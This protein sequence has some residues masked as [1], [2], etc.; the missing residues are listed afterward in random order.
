MVAGSTAGCGKG[1]G[2]GCATQRLRRTFTKDLSVLDR[3]ASQL[4]E[5]KTCCNLSHSGQSAIRGKESP[6]R[7]GQS[8]HPKMPTRRKTTDHVKCFAKRSLAY[9]KGTTQG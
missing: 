2:L 6:S 9:L 7:P 1:L 8:Q 3:K 4:H 5:A